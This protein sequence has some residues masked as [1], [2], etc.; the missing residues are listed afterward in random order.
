[1]L[2]LLTANSLNISVVLDKHIKCPAK[3]NLFLKI[4]GKQGGYHK[5]ESALTT[6]DLFDDLLV[7]ESSKTEIIIKG[8]YAGK[9]DPHNNL[10]TT[11]LDFFHKEFSTSKNLKITITKNIPVL[12]GLGGGSSNAAYF[13]IALNNIFELNLSSKKLQE[14]SFNFGSD[15]AFFIATKKSALIKGRG[16][17]DEILEL[18]DKKILL[19]NPNKPLSTKEVFN[20]YN[21][22]R[23]PRFARN[24]EDKQSS[25]VIASEAWQSMSYT[26]LAKIENDLQDTA[27]KLLPEIKTILTTFK[28]KGAEIAKMS[29]SGPTCFAIFN[30]DEDLKNCYNYFNKNHPKYFSLIA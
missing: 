16:E 14:L 8:E 4:V 23:L 22:T 9:V 6:I 19:V 5:L 13:M 30:N 1:M 24:D 28:E 26:D 29:G 2:F 7:E 17:V 12:A 21:Q 10:F 15:I 20:H 11:I 18:E 25:L 27:I 3:I